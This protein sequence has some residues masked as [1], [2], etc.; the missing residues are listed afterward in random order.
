M[1]V[2]GIYLVISSKPTHPSVRSYAWIV[3]LGA[4]LIYCSSLYI[5]A[6]LNPRDR[7]GA[8]WTDPYLQFTTWASF[9]ICLFAPLFSKTTWPARLGISLIALPILVVAW[10]CWW[11]FTA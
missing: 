9:L 5:S 7:E 6:H 1:L 4:L 11:T 2:L 8:S 10:F 3:S